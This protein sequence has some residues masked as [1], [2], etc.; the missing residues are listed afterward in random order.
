MLKLLVPVDGSPHSQRVIQYI[1]GLAQHECP[2]IDVH[3]LNVQGPIE[4]WEVKRFMPPDEIDALLAGRGGDALV[5]ARALLDQT[6]VRYTLHVKIGPVAET[7]VQSVGELNCNHIV[8]GTRGMGA[9][10][11]LLLGSIATQVIHLCD[12]PVTLIK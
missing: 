2:A 12:V 7:I 11:N 3:V 10:G 1:I 6:G 5:A 9:A 8:M 4:A